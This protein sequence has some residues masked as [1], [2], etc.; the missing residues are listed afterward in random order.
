[1]QNLT[2]H[3]GNEHKYYTGIIFPHL[4][5]SESP[6]S[7][8]QHVGKTTYWFQ[9]IIFEEMSNQLT[10]YSVWK[11]VGNLSFLWTFWNSSV[12]SHFNWLLHDFELVLLPQLHNVLNSF[13]CQ[14]SCQIFT[15]SIQWKTRLR[16]LPRRG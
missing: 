15:G 5:K 6:H 14:W 8:F 16:S 7:Q 9:Y 1:M 13:S 12:G 3:Q 10:E 4:R 2:L 11:A